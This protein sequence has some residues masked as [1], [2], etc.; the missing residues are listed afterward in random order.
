MRARNVFLMFLVLVLC[1]T[2]SLS[3]SQEKEVEFT[4]YSDPANKFYLKSPK[5]WLP[6]DQKSEIVVYIIVETPDNDPINSLNVQKIPVS[7][8]GEEQPKV[9]IDL[10]AQQLLDDLSG[11]DRFSINSD[12]YF[13]VNDRLVREFDMNYDYKGKNLRQSQAVLYNDG[14]VY[15]IVY[16]ADNTV[17]N[18][19]IYSTAISSFNFTE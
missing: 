10:L 18:A 11:A 17:Y 13:T 7:F 6:A 3:F 14:F 9:A 19:K 1:S 2:V 5:G 12:K 16:T 15:V 8:P 4:V